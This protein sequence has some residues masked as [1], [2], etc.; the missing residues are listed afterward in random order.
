MRQMRQMSN[1]M[2]SLFADPFAS[3]MGHGGGHGGF[4]FPG[5]MNVGMPRNALMPMGFGGQSMN[6]LLGGDSMP[7]NAISYSSS[8][9]FSMSSGPGQVPQV[10]QASS[11]TRTGP[12]K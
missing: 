5:L 11:S 2:N 7:E 12:G 4:G 10:Y 8:S 3:M 6:R 9:V 1:M